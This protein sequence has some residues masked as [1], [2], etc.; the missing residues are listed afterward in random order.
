M[1]IWVVGTS[2]QRLITGPCTETKFSKKKVGTG[3]TAFCTRHSICLNICLMLSIVVLSTTK[4]F[5]SFLK[6][7]FHFSENLFQS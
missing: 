1:D 3:K 4:Q 2:N 5:S 7:G 6:K